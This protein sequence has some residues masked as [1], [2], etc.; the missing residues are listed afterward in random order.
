MLVTELQ[1]PKP[2][3]SA[4]EWESDTDS[5]GGASEVDVDVVIQG[6]VPDVPIPA[7]P[8]IFGPHSTRIHQFRHGEPR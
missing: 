5:I 2:S 1:N 8:R 4:N 6:S 7:P 3:A